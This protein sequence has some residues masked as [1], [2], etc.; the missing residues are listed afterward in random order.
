MF[1][2][3]RV[4]GC[5][6]TRCVSQYSSLVQLSCF[7]TWSTRRNDRNVKRTRN[8]KRVGEVWRRLMF[9]VVFVIFIHYF[10]VDV[11]SSELT[12]R[13]L[14]GWNL[15]RIWL[16]LAGNL[17]RIWAGI[18]NPL[19]LFFEVLFAVGMGAPTGLRLDSP[20]TILSCC[21]G[22]SMFMIITIIMIICDRKQG[23]TCMTNL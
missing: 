18:L 12:W 5:A 1:V 10:G 19:P 4:D 22:K 13:P 21:I 23:Q 7:P 2:S 3:R 17:A 11:K 16:D 20:H 15:A 14:E 9:D 8:E 6:H